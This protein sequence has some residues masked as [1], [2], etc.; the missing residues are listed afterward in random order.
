MPERSPQENALVLEAVVHQDVELTSSEF[1][2]VFR[3]LDS[4][5]KAIVLA[6]TTALIDYAI[7]AHDSGERL[8]NAH[9]QSARP[10]HRH[11]RFYQSGG[12]VHGPSSARLPQA[13]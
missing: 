12:E 1:I 9:I 11:S 4:I 2:S 8:S 13:H 6:E 10:I 3:W 5:S 7:S